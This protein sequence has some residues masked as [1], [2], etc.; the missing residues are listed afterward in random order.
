MR[1][2]R[3][4]V[5]GLITLTALVLVSC[6]G[7]VDEPV[8]A[9]IPTVT[10]S[11][12]TS[13][14]MATS[15]ETATTSTVTPPIGDLEGW[16]RVA[17]SSMVFGGD[18][19]QEMNA[20]VQWESGFLAVGGDGDGDDRNAAVW[21]SDSGLDWSRISSPEGLHA[22]GLQTLN[23]V[24]IGGPGI[25]AV[26]TSAPGNHKDDAAVWTSTD[27]HDWLRV[28]DDSGVFTGPGDHQMLDVAA[29]ESGLVA[30][31]LVG[32]LDSIDAAVWTSHD[33][34]T[35]S[36]TPHNDEAFGGDG[37][38]FMSGIAVGSFGVVAVGGDDSG[39]DLDA[40]AWLSPDGIEWTRV[41]QDD[42][43]GGPGD[44]AIANIT[45]GGPGLVA[46]G[47][48]KTG[49][50]F[51]A[52]AWTSP[53]G[54]EWT[55]VPDNG[56]LGG[57]GDQVISQIATTQQGLLAVGYERITD[58]NAQLWI[59]ADGTDWTKTSNPT[60]IEPGLQELNG[61]AANDSRIAAVGYSGDLNDK[62]AAAWHHPN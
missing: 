48:E 44:Q 55:R 16:V 60:L 40:A 2:N 12:A 25:V 37:I 56:A 52:A 1:R 36:R 49:T 30:V 57:P 61:A 42:A 33:G 34:L 38:Q 18:G 21:V 58:R 8:E 43:L 46:V 5:R 22:D 53:D 39:G 47:R 45:V 54:V 41:L 9:T 11:Q 31:G 24:A 15:T 62:N 32:S 59:S 23:A 13:T 27:G 4:L 3:L 35:W 28:R 50:D 10:N 14:T 7:S 26:G 17:D 29:T 51:D 19:S 20:V 6:G